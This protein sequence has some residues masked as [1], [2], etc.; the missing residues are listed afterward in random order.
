MSTLASNLAQK[1]WISWCWGHNIFGQCSSGVLF[2]ARKKIP[3]PASWKL[4]ECP[5]AWV[6]SN[7]LR[8]G[9]NLVQSGTSSLGWFGRNLPSTYQNRFARGINV[10]ENLYAA[11]P[12][13]NVHGDVDFI[14]QVHA[15]LAP[16]GVLICSILSDTVSLWKLPFGYFLIFISLNE[17]HRKHLES[18]IHPTKQPTFGLGCALDLLRLITGKETCLRAQRK[19]WQIHPEFLLWDSSKQPPHLPSPVLSHGLDEKEVFLSDSTD[20]R[21]YPEFMTPRKTPKITRA[22]IKIYVIGFSLW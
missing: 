16:L 15:R 21:M 12:D 22:L 8:V 19:L 17:R 5:L 1:G 7:L 9:K 20:Q 11:A 4:S 3:L 10:E 13:Q 2:W 6:R 14:T 18:L